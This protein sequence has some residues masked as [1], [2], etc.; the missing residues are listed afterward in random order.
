MRSTSIVYYFEISLEI[1]YF[2]DYSLVVTMTVS[3]KSDAL[4]T[5]S[6][7]C[8]FGL[9][10]HLRSR[11]SP[12]VSKILLYKT[13]VRPVLLWSANADPRQVWRI[14]SISPR[15]Y[16]YYGEVVQKGD[17]RCQKNLYQ[18][19]EI[20]SS[21]SS[22]RWA[23]Q[24]PRWTYPSLSQHFGKTDTGVPNYGVVVLLLMMIIVW[25]LCECSAQTVGNCYS[26]LKIHISGPG[27]LSSSET[28]PNVPQSYKGR[29]KSCQTINLHIDPLFLLVV[30]F[31]LL[32]KG[33]YDYRN[34]R[35]IIGQ[36]PF[37]LEHS[38]IFKG[39]NMKLV[40]TV[41]CPLQCP[42][43]P[44]RPLCSLDFQSFLEFFPLSPGHSY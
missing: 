23:G 40:R 7:Q 29:S 27:P 1:A 6:S 18:E 34:W 24:V 19:P 42:V 14:T 30:K 20:Y 36:S 44:L 38:W 13:L 2:E 11:L 5:K 32:L 3:E 39:T 35:D 21:L 26:W 9:R 4:M 31:I 15:N 12:R 16:Y 17:W 43:A 10:L 22:L 28:T 8:F 25:Q 41:G 37:L 33:W